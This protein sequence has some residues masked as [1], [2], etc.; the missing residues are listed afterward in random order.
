[1][2]AEIGL[3]LQ[4]QTPPADAQIRRWVATLGRTQWTLVM[5]VA[6]AS[7]TANRDAR[8]AAPPEPAVRSLYRRGVRIAFRDPVE[9][10]DLAV[11]GDDLRAAGVPAGPAIGRELARL[12]EIVVGD[13]STNRRDVLLGLVRGAG[14]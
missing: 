4:R 2:G 1:V 9:L 13:P 5:R 6:S 14:R 7:W 3:A 12:L 10:A 11:D 8:E